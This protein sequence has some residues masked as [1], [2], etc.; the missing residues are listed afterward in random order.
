MSPP[1][2]RPLLGHGIGD[3]IEVE[4]PAGDD[5]V[6]GARHLQIRN[7][8]GVWMAAKRVPA[9]FSFSKGNKEACAPSAGKR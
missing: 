2:A 4:V 5:G 8:G 6:R 9:A 1:W 3:K 7:K